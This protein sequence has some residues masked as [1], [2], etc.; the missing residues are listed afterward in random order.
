MPDGDREDEVVSGWL[1]EPVEARKPVIHPRDPVTGVE[2]H[3]SVAEFPY[4]F[5][6]YY[7]VASTGE[8]GGVASCP[9]ANLQ[10]PRRLD[11][12]Q[13]LYWRKHLS[14]SQRFQFGN[15]VRRIYSIAS[16]HVWPAH[17]L[18]IDGPTSASHP[19]RD[20]RPSSAQRLTRTLG[21]S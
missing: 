3:P 19:L 16:Q 13:R 6:R 8:P 18:K 5:D 7:V 9:R 14:R 11:G 10:H 17:A 4:R 12:Q 1:W 20:I 2:F 15:Q 21:P